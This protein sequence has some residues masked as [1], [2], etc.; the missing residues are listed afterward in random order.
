[1]N[2]HA[3]RSGFETLIGQ[4]MESRG[5]QFEYESTT[6]DYLTTVRGGIC[7]KCE[8]K[9][10]YQRRKYKPDFI[11][12]RDGDRPDLIIEAKG[13]LDAPTRSKMQDIKRANPK[14]DIRFLFYGKGTWARGK[15]MKEWADKNGFP[16]AFGHEVPEDWL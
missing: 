1:M 7:S 13:V 11:V 5:I 3:Y 2:K 6:F 15:K 9:R 14:A 16:C 10:V 4:D 12:P 8:C